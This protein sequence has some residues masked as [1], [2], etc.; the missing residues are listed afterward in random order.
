M[1]TRAT[2]ILSKITGSVNESSQKGKSIKSELELA[3]YASEFIKKNN[4]KR[5]PDPLSNYKDNFLTP[6]W[7]RSGAVL[8]YKLPKSA[9]GLFLGYF[10][11]GTKSGVVFDTPI[12]ETEFLAL[13]RKLNG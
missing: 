10:N 9:G 4:I 5:V 7:K 2:N 12:S 13:T 11:S 3:E 1:S 6:Q 8:G